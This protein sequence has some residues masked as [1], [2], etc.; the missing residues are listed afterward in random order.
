M[1][2]RASI[3]SSDGSGSRASP[4]A[5]ASQQ[6]SST[7]EA[8]TGVE[9]VVGVKRKKSRAYVL[10]EDGEESEGTQADAEYG[11]ARAGSGWVNI[12]GRRRSVQSGSSSIR[13][14]EGD[15]ARRHSMA[16]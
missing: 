6:A 16:V 13:R 14:V 9:P 1:T 2:K 11:G 15:D 7:L 5:V 10:P 3:S 12:D 8:G 4:E